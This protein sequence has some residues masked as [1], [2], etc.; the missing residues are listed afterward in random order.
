VEQ[1]SF[2]FL[3][4]SGQTK[5]SQK[6]TQRSVQTA[7]FEGEELEVFFGDNLEQAILL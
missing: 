7:P 5:S 3:S 1:N 2:A 6:L 4:F